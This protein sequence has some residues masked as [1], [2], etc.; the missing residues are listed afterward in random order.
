[1]SAEVEVQTVV[2]KALGDRGVHWNYFVISFQ[3]PTP[4]DHNRASRVH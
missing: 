3:G 2:T 1:M 4:K